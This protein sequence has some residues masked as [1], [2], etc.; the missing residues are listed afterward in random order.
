MHTERHLLS[1]PMRRRRACVTGT[2]TRSGQTLI[3]VV[4]IL[5]ILFFV[6][7][8]NFD[9]H[10]ILFVKFLS[11]NAGDS[12][13]MA[14]A[15]WQGTS[16][17]L[18]GDL[19]IV[20]A[21]AM[22]DALSGSGGTDVI[23]AIDDLQARICYAGPMIGMMA[24]QQAAK[25]NKIH[26]N[27]EFTAYLK[28]HVGTILNEYPEFMIEA[29]PNCFEEYATMLDTICNNGIV[30]G[31]E[32]MQ[33]YTDYLGH[34]VLLDKSFYF[35]IATSAWCWFFFL[36]DDLLYTYTSYLD[37]PPMDKIANPNPINCE[38]YSLCLEKASFALDDSGLVSLMNTIKNSRNL[39]GGSIDSEVLSDTPT[40]WYCYGARWEEPFAMSDPG[41][42]SA[43]SVRP[44]FNYAGADTVVRVE[45]A[46]DLATPGTEIG[47]ITWTAAAKPLGYLAGEI[48]P[49]AYDIVLPAFHDVRLIPI[50]ASSAGSSGSFDLSF[51]KHCEQH[52]P[53]Y[54]DAGP[55]ALVQSCWYCKQLK[56]WE[57]ASFRA[58]GKSWLAANSSQCNVTGG[59]G[60]GPGG[61]TSIGH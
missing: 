60:G 29:Y 49:N 61:G 46:P 48:K 25:N 14:G 22:T 1:T 55:S 13:A 35:A 34:H 42:P 45:T 12:A 41:F 33:L 19:N 32:N 51:R 17:N 43:G 38:F 7:L 52:L 21:I 37:W 18:I 15:R 26:N 44:Q 16:L 54:L 24:S 10:K 5:I 59:P 31:P 4:M 40:T 20:K 28:N 56:T 3:F 57:L 36:E 8:W 23:G 27:K 58:K 50:N 47:E 39:P 9:L 6:V 30:A 2:S 53:D 11:Q